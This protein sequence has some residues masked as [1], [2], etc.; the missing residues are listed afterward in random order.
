MGIHDIALCGLAKRDEELFV[1]WQDTGPVVL[2]SGG[3]ASLVPRQAG[4]R[5]RGAT[6]S[7]PS[8]FHRQLRGKGTTASIDDVTG[9]GPGAHEGPLKRFRSFRNLKS[10]T[11][12]EIKEARVVPNDVA[13]ELFT[14]APAA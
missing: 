2:P 10:A 1:P 11:L 14:R 12:E 13:E 7:P 3:R 4:A 5:R 8:T 6:A 9:M